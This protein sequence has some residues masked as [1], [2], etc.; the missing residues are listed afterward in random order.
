M[1]QLRE[2]GCNAVLPGRVALATRTGRRIPNVQDPPLDPSRMAV[3]LE[4]THRQ[5][6]I[7]QLR[8]GPSGQY[9]AHGL[10]FASR[11]TQIVDT[12]IVQRILADEGYREVR[13]REAVPG[14][15][16]LYWDGN[17]IAHSGIL[18]DVVEDKRSVGGLV[19]RVLSKWG[20]GGEYIHYAEHCP[21]A[22]AGQRI[23]F[24]TDRDDDVP[25]RPATTP[26]R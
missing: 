24:W 2:H 5:F 15:V 16:V 18:Q 25:I 12:E 17:E 4:R 22:T 10:T 19:A 1:A 3:Y 26:L 11:R 8:R 21:Y 23:T 13:L 7:A 14:D 9:N 6:P 20:A